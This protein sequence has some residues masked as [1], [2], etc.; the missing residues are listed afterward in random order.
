[1]R[2]GKRAALLAF[3]DA[4]IIR[5]SMYSS[6]VAGFD[7]PRLLAEFALGATVATLS[8]LAGFLAS[9]RSKWLTILAGLAGLVVAAAW[10]WPNFTHADFNPEVIGGDGRRLWWLRG[11]AWT[12]LAD[13]AALLAVVGLKA[14]RRARV[15]TGWSAHQFVVALSSLSLAYIAF[16]FCLF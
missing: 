3:S 11:A 16:K 1:V 8:G 6:R 2:K 9:E 10:I 14:S 7:D 15:F 5:D 12:F 13:G 4:K